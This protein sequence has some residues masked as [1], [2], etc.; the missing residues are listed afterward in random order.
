MNLSSSIFLTLL[1]GDIFQY[2]YT[3]DE[4][5]IWLPRGAWTKKAIQKQLR[6]L[7]KKKIISYKAP[8]YCVW[9][10]AK[11]RKTRLQREHGSLGKWR[12]AESAASLLRFIPTITLVG[13]T[14]GLS[15]FNADTDDDIDFYIGT[16]PGT[17]WI[18]RFFATLLIEAAGIRRHPEDK[19]VK[20][21]ICLNMFVSE[22]AF[23]VS[24]K[25]QDIFTAHEVLQMKP[26]WERG[27]TYAH[28]LKKNKWVSSI[29]PNKWKEVMYRLKSKKEIIREYGQFQFLT[30]F[31]RMLEKPSNK[32]Q[33]WYMNKRRTSE[34][35]SDTVVRFHPHDARLWIHKRLQL[36]LKRYHL[37]LDKNFFHP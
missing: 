35:V 37:P 30:Q 33:L 36:K 29:F 25:E 22:K 2:P 9:R 11:Y 21:V 18:S 14:G 10:H 13:I 28:F 4:L 20:D 15:N 27:N 17:L 24:K 23:M 12:K 5:F 3:E 8:F 31:L 32:I 34:V 16:K 19:D 6:Y 26:L 1:Y 7:I